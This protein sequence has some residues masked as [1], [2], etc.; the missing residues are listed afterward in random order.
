MRTVIGQTGMPSVARPDDQRNGRLHCQALSDRGQKTTTPQRPGRPPTPCAPLLPMR[1]S[2]QCGGGVCWAGSTSWPD[3]SSDSTGTCSLYSSGHGFGRWRSRASEST[4]TA[5]RRGRSAG[6]PPPVRAT[7]PSRDP[8]A[9]TR[10]LHWL[11][12]NAR[13][14]H[15]RAPRAPSYARAHPPV[16]LR[17][18]LVVS[19]AARRDAAEIRAH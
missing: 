1:S 6:R 7:K 19:V 8:C 15:S 16:R 10:S 9:R 11:G 12:V 18:T 3:S 17:R 2:G 13:V 14:T 5:S 4:T